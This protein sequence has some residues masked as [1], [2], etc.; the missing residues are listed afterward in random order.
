M[1][2]AAKARMRSKGSIGGESRTLERMLGRIRRVRTVSEKKN[3]KSRIG[4][5]Q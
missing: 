3:Q 2:K 4:K 1:S 5:D